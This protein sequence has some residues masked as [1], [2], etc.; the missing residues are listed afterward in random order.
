MLEAKFT[1]DAIKYDL[2][3]MH[4]FGVADGLTNNEIYDKVRKQLNSQGLE[5]YAENF[6]G[7]VGESKRELKRYSSSGEIEREYGKSW[8]AEHYERALKVEANEKDAKYVVVRDFMKATDSQINLRQLDEILRE[9]VLVAETY[10]PKVKRTLIIKRKPREVY[11]VREKPVPVQIGEG[12]K[13]YGK[14]FSKG[15]KKKKKGIL[16]K[17][18]EKTIGLFGRFSRKSAYA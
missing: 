17:M 5:I 9:E 16:E 1:T 7:Q 2:L 3:A 15:Q 6:F 14:F 11:K 4:E 10:I 18:A 13:F 12:P 8:F